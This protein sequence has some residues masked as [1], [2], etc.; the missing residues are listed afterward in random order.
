MLEKSTRVQDP[1]LQLSFVVEPANVPL[2]VDDTANVTDDSS[3]SSEYI[4]EEESQI[5]I[6]TEPSCAPPSI[7][8]VP[9]P[10]KLLHLSA[11]LVQP[12]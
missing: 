2:A 3:E 4:A 5:L 1:H 7:R 10:C 11:L 9:T 6:S 8:Y 12:L